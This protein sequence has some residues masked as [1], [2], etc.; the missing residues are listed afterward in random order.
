VTTDRRRKFGLYARYA[1]PF[2]WIVNQEA[3]A[4]EPYRLE[5]SSDALA[6][7]AEGAE[8]CDPPPFPGLPLRVDDLWP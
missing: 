1:V 5:G 4:A 6:L 7:R 8:A 2:Y 3:R